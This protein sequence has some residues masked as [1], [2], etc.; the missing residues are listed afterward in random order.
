MLPMK[1]ASF[2]SWLAWPPMAVFM[3]P[4]PMRSQRSTASRPSA[5]PSFVV[6]S[7]WPLRL[8]LTRPRSFI[9]RWMPPSVFASASSGTC[10]VQ[11]RTALNS[12]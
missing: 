8:R 9:M 11:P 5:R 3:M 4:M 2:S 6:R 1:A 12:T 7:E 10:S